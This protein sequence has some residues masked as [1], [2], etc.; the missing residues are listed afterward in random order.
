MLVISDQ[1]CEARKSWA[2][3]AAGTDAKPLGAS[4]AA[5]I[6]AN[7]DVKKPPPV[8]RKSSWAD[9]A[10]D[11][12]NLSSSTRND[13]SKRS[14]PAKK[15]KP[16]PVKRGTA[17]YTK[18]PPG[19]ER[20]SVRNVYDGDTLTLTDGRRV[21]FLG[22]D[23]P[24]ISEGQPYAKEAKAYAKK[25]CDKKDI[26]L[27]Y[28]NYGDRMDKFGRLLAF[29]W[30]ESMS[31]G[32]GYICINEGI[33]SEGLATVY[34]PRKDAKLR[35]LKTLLRLQ[36]GARNAKRGIWNNFVDYKVL[37]TP[38]GSAFH[39]AGCKHIANHRKLRTIMA[40][41]AAD[42]GLHPCRTCLADV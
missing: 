40:S 41:Q 26:W 31:Q 30:A 8:K 35:N 32:G 1:S 36:K 39:K 6:Q 37:V 18:L 34:L 42:S 13:V 11:G 4:G 3:V 2:D 7:N 16:T 12:S 19:A 17:I 21:R 29:V 10:S 9:I 28:D 5:T 23:T 33:V 20:H 22:I 15:V 25:Y 38:F 14:P 27:T 24:E